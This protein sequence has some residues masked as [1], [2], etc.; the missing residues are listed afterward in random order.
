M[1]PSRRPNVF[2]RFVFRFLEA[3]GHCIQGLEENGRVASFLYI[4][5]FSTALLVPVGSYVEMVIGSG[6]FD[7]LFFI[8]YFFRSL[9]VLGLGERRGGGV[10]GGWVREREEERKRGGREG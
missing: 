9:R 5:A 3:F 2:F 10:V 7:F 8:F 1:G 4:L 6:G